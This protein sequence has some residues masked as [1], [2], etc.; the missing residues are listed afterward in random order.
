[1]IYNDEIKVGQVLWLKIRTD[2]NVISRN[3]LPVLVIDISDKF[4]EVIAL[5][6]ISN[7]SKISKNYNYFISLC[8]ETVILRD[9]YAKLDAKITI[10]YTDELKRARKTLDTISKDKLD[11]ILSKYNDYHVKHENIKD[12]NMNIYEIL[13]LNPYIQ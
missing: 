10:G 2:I 13:F 3:R 12:I 9:C 1:M 7:K 11:D 5:E 4:V 8:D 6:S